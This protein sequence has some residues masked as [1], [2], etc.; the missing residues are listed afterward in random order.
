[1]PKLHTERFPLFWRP[2]LTAAYRQL[3]LLY[4]KYLQTEAEERVSGTKIFK[5]DA[6]VSSSQQ[7]EQVV[8]DLSPLAPPQPRIRDSGY[9]NYGDDATVVRGGSAFEG[10]MA[11]YRSPATA[12]SS[13][14][15]FPCDPETG[16]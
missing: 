15:K 14:G 2:H 9:G 13:D 6:T 10:S 11:N 16:Q 3:A 7:P 5:M 1:M 8:A 4:Q 12:Y